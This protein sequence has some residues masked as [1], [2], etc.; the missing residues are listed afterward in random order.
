MKTRTRAVVLKHVSSALSV[1]LLL[2]QLGACA[3][4]QHPL[5]FQEPELRVE[6]A[7]RMFWTL[8][9]A[10]GTTTGADTTIPGK[11]I[12]YV[13]GTLHLGTPELYPLDNRSFQALAEADLVFA[14]LNPQEMALGPELVRS[15]MG[16]SMLHDGIALRTLLPSDDVAWLE[17]FIG[18]SVFNVL[19]RYEPWVAYSAIDQF[20]ASRLDLDP[21]QG[22]DAVIFKEAARLGKHVEGLE[23][24]AYQLQLLSSPNLSL[25][26]LLLRDSIREYRNH[27]DALL[28]LYRAYLEDDRVALERE[29]SSSIAR[30][31]SFDPALAEFNNALLSERNEA[32]AR[33]LAGLLDQGQTVYLFAGVAHFVGPGN[34]LERLEDY[35]YRLEQPFKRP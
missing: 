20:A 31:E 13:Q 17:A 27:A 25:Q 21:T 14:E 3:S 11:G 1:F 33:R 30:S 32:W 4:Q 7:P 12:L 8:K 2:L 34:V 5:G 10:T 26:V 6:P 23:T 29:L 16:A 9:T 18:T 22:V 19:E 24:A 15:R 28:N 35:G